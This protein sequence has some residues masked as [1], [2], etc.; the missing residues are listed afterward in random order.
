M[1]TTFVPD[2]EGQLTQ[3]EFWNLYKDTFTPHQEKVPLLVAS[4]VIILDIISIHKGRILKM[5]DM[6]EATGS[7]GSLSPR[8]THC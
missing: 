4:D 3:V 8:T 6:A 2:S 5:S 1:R 7:L